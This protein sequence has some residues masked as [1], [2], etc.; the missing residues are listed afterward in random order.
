MPLAK[1]H[2]ASWVKKGTLGVTP[3][4]Q[5]DSASHWVV[6]ASRLDLKAC[7]LSDV[8]QCDLLGAVAPG[9]IQL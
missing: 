9:T 4:L 6:L 1:G 3:G 7:F 2:Q 8:V 5:H